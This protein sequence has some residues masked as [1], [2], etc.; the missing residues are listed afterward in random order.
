MSPMFQRDWD[1]HSSHLLNEIRYVDI[2]M[3]N[4]KI[5]SILKKLCH[6]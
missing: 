5:I 3:E 1:L 4:T 6:N 2:R